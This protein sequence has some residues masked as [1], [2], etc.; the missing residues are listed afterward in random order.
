MSDQFG[1]PETRSSNTSRQ[2]FVSYL[3]PLLAVLLAW[4]LAIAAIV[5]E[6]S[7]MPSGTKDTDL[8]IVLTYFVVQGGGAFLI[9]GLI[10]LAGRLAGKLTRR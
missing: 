8:L 9:W 1:A 6:A 4:P 3:V 7:A 2:S 10:I 5:A